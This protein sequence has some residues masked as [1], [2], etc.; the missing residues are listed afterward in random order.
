M[1]VLVIMTTTTWLT[2]RKQ[3]NVRK[4]FVI[5]LS[6]IANGFNMVALGRVIF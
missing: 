4:I 1:I 6:L 5:W 3:S 2:T